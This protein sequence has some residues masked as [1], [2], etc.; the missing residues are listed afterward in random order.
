MGWCV[1]DEDKVNNMP[2]EER[3]GRGYVRRDETVFNRAGNRVEYEEFEFKGTDF[4]EG[5]TYRRIDHNVFDDKWNLIG[6]FS[7]MCHTLP[8]FDYLDDDGLGEPDDESRYSP[9]EQPVM[10]AK[11]TITCYP[12]VTKHVP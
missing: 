4:E 6:W 5:R 3:L 7:P 12:I 1:R 10:V 2:L 8:E 9:A 11:V